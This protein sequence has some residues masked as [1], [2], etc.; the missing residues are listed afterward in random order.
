MGKLI[1]QRYGLSNVWITD[2]RNIEE[3]W[4][5]NFQILDVTDK[6]KFHKIVVEN[7]INNI[8]HLA[9]MTSEPSEK[10]LELAQKT[11]IQGVHNSLEIARSTK[12]M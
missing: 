8:I 2:N 4:Q 3:K 9:C 7:K 5:G 12:S 6:E 11:N 10:N 1:A